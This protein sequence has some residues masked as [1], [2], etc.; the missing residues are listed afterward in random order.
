MK[1]PAK[2]RRLL[3]DC[4]NPM[5]I[6]HLRQ[7]Q[8]DDWRDC[9]DPEDQGRRCRWQ[10]G[11]LRRGKLTVSWNAYWLP[12]ADFVWW[13]VEVR[14]QPDLART[15]L[16]AS[17]SARLYPDPVPLSEVAEPTEDEQLAMEWADL[18]GEPAYRHFKPIIYHPTAPGYL[19]LA[20]RSREHCQPGTWLPTEQLPPIS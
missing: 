20:W 5:V 13:L 12:D 8:A 6:D 4:I 2:L 19:S 9:L 11:Q 1:T 7:S 17:L 3:I 10:A 18:A 16:P 15:R 14:R